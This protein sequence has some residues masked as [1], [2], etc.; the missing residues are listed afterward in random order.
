MAKGKESSGNDSRFARELMHLAATLY[1]VESATQAEIAS[2]L[3]VSRPTV[4]RLL[5][6][7]RKAKLVRITVEPLDNHDIADLARRT[8]GAL[9][10]RHLEVAGLTQGRHLGPGLAPALGV[11]L[12]RVGLKAGDVLLVA[13]GRTI[14]EVAQCE[15]AELP[16]VLVVP[17][18]GGQDEAEAWYQANEITRQ[19]AVAVGGRP[20]FLYAPALPGPALHGRLLDDPS[21]GRVISLWS[22]AR[23]AVL[24]I[25]AP[26]WQRE[27]ISTFIPAGAVSLRDAVGDVCLRFFDRDGAPVEFPGSERLVSTP[28]EVLRDVPVTIG[29]AVGADKVNGIIAAARAGYINEL[30]TDATTVAELAVAL[31]L[32]PTDPPT[33]QPMPETT[34]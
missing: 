13:T 29:L 11:A 28:L 2:R 10:L 4:S 14:Y 7:A 33:R 23:C 16:G 19:F 34:P 15:L 12:R 27:S 8:A 20:T 24:G 17:A 5:A 3:E 1:Y 9:G 18:V 30:V 6:E 32:D 26:P 31:H 22:H 21:T 25:G